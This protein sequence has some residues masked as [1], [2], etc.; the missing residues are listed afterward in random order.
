MTSVVDACTSAIRGCL[1]ASPGKKLV[2]A[3]LSNIE[4]RTAA[5]LAGEDWKL[6]AFRDFDSGIGHDLYIIAYSRSF[7][8]PPEVVI[9]NKKY[10]DGYMR[11]IGKVQ[12]LSLQYQGG[13]NAFRKMAG[14][15]ATT[16]KDDEIAEIVRAWRLAHP[17]IKNMWYGLENAARAAIKD[18][19]ASYHVGPLGF[20]CQRDA[21]GTLWLR[22]RLPSGRY[23][24][25]ARPEI[26]SDECH[27]CNGTGQVSWEGK[28]YACH[29]CNGSGK[30][31]NGG[32]ITYE[33]V[34]QYTRQWARIDAYGG[35][36]FEQSTQ[37][38]AR[39]IFMSGFSRAMKAGYPV[40][41]R[42]HDELVADTPDSPEFNSDHLARIMATNDAWNIGLPLAAA[43]HEAYRYGKD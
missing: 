6:Q 14:A 29:E 9:E 35:K 22:L 34:N 37:A 31:L 10:G 17:R 43:G 5:W 19:G 21:F 24:C 3:D 13:V 4:G 36:F 11:Q 16:M 2:V 39:D 32:R 33:G 23:I 38:T 42:V 12:E 20:D 26:T 15:L 8:V 30:N 41:L 40:V 1:V 7:N 27:T 18:E 28:V 25:Y